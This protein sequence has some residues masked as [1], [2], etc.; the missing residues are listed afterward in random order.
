MDFDESM[1]R[2]QDLSETLKCSVAEHPEFQEDINSQ[3]KLL[4]LNLQNRNI[5]SS[6]RQYDIDNSPGYQLIV[7]RFGKISNTALSNIAYQLS[8]Q[9]GIPISRDI[10]RKSLYIIKWIDCHF[11]QLAPL[12]DN[13]EIFNDKNDC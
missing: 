7:N 11:Q 10:T 12:F 5:A 13:I 8:S 6:D 4:L 1:S 2:L 9:S 3:L